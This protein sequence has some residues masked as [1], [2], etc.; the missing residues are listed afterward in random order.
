M[1]GSPKWF[2]PSG[3]LTKTLYV[4][5]VPHTHYMPHTSHSSQFYDHNNIGWAVQIIQHLIMQLPPLPC[6]HI[7]TRPKYSPQHPILI[8]CQPTF[9]PQCQ[10][11]YITLKSRPTKLSGFYSLRYVLH[12]CLLSL[13]DCEKFCILLHV[14]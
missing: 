3:F 5:P 10:P 6:Y 2:F 14:L 7:P 4:S 11:L 13:F 12:W 8:H 1:P 9:L